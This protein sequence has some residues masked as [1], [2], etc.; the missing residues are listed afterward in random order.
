MNCEIEFHPDVTTDIH[1]AYKWYNSQLQGLGDRLL[2]ELED[3]YTAIQNFPDT[4]ANFQHGFKR[5]ILNKFPFSIV[6]KVSNK[7]I[8]VVVVMHNSRKPEYWKDR[9]S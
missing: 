2:D 4:W 3:G 6:Y 7:K 1:I 8:Y 9:I 5:F